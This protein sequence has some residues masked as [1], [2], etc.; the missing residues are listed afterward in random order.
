[1][2]EV[3]E[4]LLEDHDLGP[5]A[6]EAHRVLQPGDDRNAAITE[7]DAQLVQIREELRRQ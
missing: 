5:A 3:R 6:G 1:M 4:G 7:R 2:A